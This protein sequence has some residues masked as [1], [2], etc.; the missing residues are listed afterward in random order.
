MSEPKPRSGLD[1]SALALAGLG[2]GGASAVVGLLDFAVGLGH[3]DLSGQSTGV[4]HGRQS[5]A[6]QKTGHRSARTLAAKGLLL[7]L[8]L[9]APAGA[10]ESPPEPPVEPAAA[11]P[12]TPA[13]ES[14]RAAVP[15]AAPGDRTRSPG[16]SAAT[17]PVPEVEAPAAD[18]QDEAAEAG[19]GTQQASAGAVRFREALNRLLIL[20]HRAQKLEQ[21]SLGAELPKDLRG[22]R[23]DRWRRITADKERFPIWMDELPRQAY[24]MPPARGRNLRP[25]EMV[26]LTRLGQAFEASRDLST[27][28]AIEFDLDTFNKTDNWA[29]RDRAVG[30][31]DTLFERELAWAQLRDQAEEIVSRGLSDE[32]LADMLS[33][34]DVLAPQ[35]AQDSASVLSRLLTDA[36][37]AGKVMAEL[38][39]LLSAPVE[40]GLPKET[41]AQLL[42]ALPALQLSLFE[43]SEL[44]QTVT[45]AQAVESE[46]VSIEKRL[47]D[48]GVDA[49]DPTT[50]KQLAGRKAEL[51]VQKN[52]IRN[53]LNATEPDLAAAELL[54][55]TQDKLIRR[56][57][58]ALGSRA[59]LFGQ[60]YDVLLDQG[61]FPGKPPAR[62]WR[63]LEDQLLLISALDSARPAPNPLEGLELRYAP[64]GPTGPVTK[65]ALLEPLAKPKPGGKSAPKKP[66]KGK[67]PR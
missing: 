27:L 29:A 3:G 21:G 24:S 8:L 20:E 59:A 22:I 17:E 57:M 63:H 51:M 34:L 58:F 23:L 14:G 50:R 52:Q 40:S 67:N 61:R 5:R 35:T 25:L 48:R 55:E 33:Q 1:V 49:P 36:A 6:V 45:D 32:V 16:D 30:K 66:A 54:R 65:K 62:I 38:T 26:V 11:E 19:A 64:A 12:E 31:R 53:V 39:A 56:R 46:L 10:Q 47:A 13:S 15:P 41:D 28:K 43:K 4:P 9:T 44:V 60:R 18:G 42:G 2:V 7:G 37:Y